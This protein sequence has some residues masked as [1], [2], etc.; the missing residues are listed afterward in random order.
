MRA[1]LLVI[2]LSLSPPPVSAF[3]FGADIAVLTQILAKA[4]LQL[5]QLR[6]IL[7]AGSSQLD[8]LR[9]VNEGLDRTVRLIQIVDPKFNPGIYKD[10]KD[11]N[12][13]IREIKRIYGGVVNTK[14]KLVQGHVDQI[15]AEAFSNNAY[16]YN[17]AKET[18][19]Y[20]ERLHQRS[21]GSNPKSAQR[22]TAQSLGVVVGQM[23]QN[24]RTQAT[25]VKLQAQAVAVQNRKDK[26]QSKQVQSARSNL[27]DTLKNYKP[28]FEIPKL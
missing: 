3:S 11:I 10:W 8:L 18:Q 9:E 25:S 21:Q 2:I 12:V 1:F 28:Q 17:Y 4:V 5:Q 19:S 22:L 24:L 7:S 23:S 6:Q 15:V 13:A 16:T 26:V 14:D 20:G 27:S